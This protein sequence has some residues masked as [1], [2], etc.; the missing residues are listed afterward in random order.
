M[1][2]ARWHGKGDIRIED[3]PIPEPGPGEVLLKIKACGICGSDLHEYRD[4]PFIIPQRPHP[5]TGR[6]G[7]PVTIGHEFSANVEAIGDSVENFKTGDRVTVNA[8]LYCSKC[9]YCRKGQYNMCVKLGTIGFAADGAFAEYV[10][11]PEY[12]LHKLPDAVD[13]DMGAFVEPAAVAVRAAKQARVGIGHTVAIIGAGP[14]GLLTMQVCRIAGASRIFVVEPMESRRDLAVKLGADVAI[15]PNETSPDKEISNL[16]GRLKADR[17]I[18]C[19]GIQASFDTAVKITGRRGIICVVG[20][21]L[22]P[23]EVPFLRMWG[24]EKEITFSTGYEDEFPAAISFLANGGVRVKELITARIGLD[25]LIEDGIKV[26]IEKAG[27]N[28]KILVYPRL[29]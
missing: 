8:L 21:S 1:K 3:T 2:A 28:I 27:K 4:G 12:T 16:T 24:H 7:G 29:G 9:H 17:T 6:V 20:L 18:D 23:I 19:V 26:S 5:L 14:I 22:T 13:D 11:V 10:T 15:D 25:N